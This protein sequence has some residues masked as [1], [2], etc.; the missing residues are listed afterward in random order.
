MKTFLSLLL[1]AAVGAGS[2]IFG[3]GCLMQHE[4]ESEDLLTFAPSAEALP[5]FEAVAIRIEQASGV[6]LNIAP[7]GIPVEFVPELPSDSAFGYDCG[8]TPVTFLSN[9][10]VI[11]SVSIDVLWPPRE[12]CD[13]PRGTLTHEV[14]HALRAKLIKTEKNMGH[15]ASGVF[16]KHGGDKLDAESLN[17]IC[18]AVVCTVYNPEE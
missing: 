6:H 11:T 13:S 9:P 1:A 2:I 4:P 16:H 7:D 17:A 15:A 18:E 10:L 12:G 8:H 3:Q 5:Y 14:I